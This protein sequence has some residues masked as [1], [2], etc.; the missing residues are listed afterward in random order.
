MTPE[1]LHNLALLLTLNAQTLS[2]WA[3]RI[4]DPEVSDEIKRVAAS[5]E[6]ARTLA[7]TDDTPKRIDRNLLVTLDVPTDDSELTAWLSRQ[8]VYLA[9]E[10]VVRAHEQRT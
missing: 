8:A 9:R 7:I 2:V 5:L 3:T 4:T 1:K 10:R 6:A